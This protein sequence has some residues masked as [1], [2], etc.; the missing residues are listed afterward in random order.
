MPV[1][2]YCGLIFLARSQSYKNRIE[3]IERRAEV[4]I[5]SNNLTVDLRLPKI[6]TAVKK[7][8]CTLVFV[9]LQ[10]NVCD[11][12]KKYFTKNTHNTKRTQEMMNYR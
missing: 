10:R 8:A 1:F 11:V 5:K 3:S 2:G 12:M 7:R 6:D 4:V 9:N